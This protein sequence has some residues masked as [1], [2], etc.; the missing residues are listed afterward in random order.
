MYITCQEVDYV[1]VLE[2][3]QDNKLTYIQ[4]FLL[5]LPGLMSL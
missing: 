4:T 5:I 3:P 1:C 2:N